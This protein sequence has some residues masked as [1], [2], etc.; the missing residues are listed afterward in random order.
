M[1]FMNVYYL[2]IKGIFFYS[3]VHSFVKFDLLRKHWLFMALLYT[4][5]M[6]FL[7]FVWIVAPGQMSFDAWKKWLVAT[8]V[9][10][11][12]YFKLLDRFDEGVLFWILL[13]AGMGIVYDAWLPV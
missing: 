1:F 6:A 8:L 3:L 7:S 4:G 5:G 13:V 11:V 2:A 12:V 9:L 10:V